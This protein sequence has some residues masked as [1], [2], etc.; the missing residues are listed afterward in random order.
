MSAAESSDSS[1]GMEKLFIIIWSFWFKV[2]SYVVVE[3]PNEGQ[4]M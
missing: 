2:R 3:S 4:V 1:Q